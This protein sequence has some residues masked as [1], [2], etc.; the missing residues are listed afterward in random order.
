MA[1][2]AFVKFITGSHYGGKSVGLLTL[3]VPLVTL[4]VIRT[5]YTKI[6]PNNKK[7]IFAAILIGIIGPLFF[8]W[9]YSVFAIGIPAAKMSPITT[10]KDLI[11]FIGMASIIGPLSVLTYSGM[12]GAMILNM[13]SSPFIGWWLSKRTGNI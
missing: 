12:L 3:L 11:S 7:N 1:C 6:L 9:S 2:Y 5:W 13:I 4:I 8:I 10:A